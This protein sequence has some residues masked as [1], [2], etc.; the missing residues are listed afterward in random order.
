MLRYEIANLYSGIDVQNVL[1]AAPEECIFLF[2]HSLLE[3][4]DH[5]ICTYPGY[6]SLYE[7]ARSIGCQV[8][9]W[10]PHEENGWRFDPGDLEDLIKPNTRLVIANF[11]HNPTGYL[12]S[13]EEFSDIIAIIQANGAFMLSDEMYRFLDAENGLTLPS[14]C[15]HYERAISLFGLS[16]S[17][18][19]PGLRIG[20]LAAQESHLIEQV[21]S[22]K[23]YTTIC[24][25][26]PSEIL[27]IIALRNKQA[28]VAQQVKRVRRNL[29]VLDDFFANHQDQLRWNRPKGGSICFPRML[30]V[31]NTYEFCKRLVSESGI[32]LAPSR[33]FHY[34]D[35]HVRIGFGR[36][37]LPQVIRL[38]AK[39]LENYSQ[40]NM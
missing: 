10:K 20:W 19:L 39:Y 40:H 25:S 24:N 17:F 37:D 3:A 18:G 31:K 36:E 11:P 22:L 1:V 14:A 30:S 5:V 38:F 7:I 2:M 13:Q 34:G 26:A 16:K 8:S 23:D 9:L 29:T 4:G 6:Q 15:E 21:A 27:A 33:T 35:Q 32:M 12:P 28:I